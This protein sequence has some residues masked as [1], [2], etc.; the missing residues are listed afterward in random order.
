MWRHLDVAPSNLTGYG[1]VL[2]SD[3]SVNG[4]ALACLP[5]ERSFSSLPLFRRKGLVGEQLIFF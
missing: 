4:A 5:P 1:L 2:S 3:M